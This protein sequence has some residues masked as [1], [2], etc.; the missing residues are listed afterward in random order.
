MDFRRALE[1][2][3]TSSH[4]DQ[5]TLLSVYLKGHCILFTTRR[6]SQFCD[7]P[8][9]AELTISLNLVSVDMAAM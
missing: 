3:V 8:K 6:L 1:A 4:R 9:E 5:Q 2:R 7:K